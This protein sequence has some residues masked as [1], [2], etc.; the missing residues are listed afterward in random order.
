MFHREIEKW[1]RV[2]V[3]HFVLPLDTGTD[4]IEILSPARARASTRLAFV[5]IIAKHGNG[6]DRRFDYSV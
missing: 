3:A 5:E 1:L 4:E 6:N 2:A